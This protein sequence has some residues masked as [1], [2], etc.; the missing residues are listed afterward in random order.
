VNSANRGRPPAQ[1][2][3]LPIQAISVPLPLAFI[4][5]KS[6]NNPALAHFIATLNLVRG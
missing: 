5:L 3:F 4:H 2:Q 1:A 6:N